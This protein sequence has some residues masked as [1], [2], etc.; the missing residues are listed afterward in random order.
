MNRLLCTAATLTSLLA[1]ACGESQPPATSER[2]PPPSVSAVQPVVQGSGVAAAPA[3]VQD[4]APGTPVPPLGAQWTIFCGSF[5]GP[6]HVLVANQAKADLLRQSHLNGWYLVHHADESILYYGYYTELGT[7]RAKADKRAIEGLSV[8][9]GEREFAA[10]MFV[11]LSSPNPSAPPEWNLANTPPE[12]YFSLQI[13][14][15]VQTPDHKE[16]AV[17]AVREARKLGIEAYYYH[18][19][20]MST[21]CVG[22]WPRTAVRQQG[23]GGVAHNDNADVPVV[24]ANQEIPDGA[25]P[26]LRDANGNPIPIIAPKLVID[27]PTLAKAIQEFPANAVNGY[28]MTQKDKN[29]HDVPASSFLVEI[30]HNAAAQADNPDASEP[31]PAQAA[32]VDGTDATLGKLGTGGGH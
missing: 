21:V 12:M 23:G 22:A 28:V 27:D 17:E 30:P 1:G 31:A 6:D 32:P 25:V 16:R 3:G 4:A 2:V 7:P 18:T 24:V 26:N 11:P 13:A 10:S 19:D 8:N 5:R 20:S 15:F 9:E 29:G 14:A